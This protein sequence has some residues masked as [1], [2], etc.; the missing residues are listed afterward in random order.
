MLDWNAQTLKLIGSS[1]VLWI[2]TKEFYAIKIFMEWLLINASTAVTSVS[3]LKVSICDIH[4]KHQI[5]VINEAIWY[6][7]L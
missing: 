5:L 3:I 4:V 7:I 2:T 6:K 1:E